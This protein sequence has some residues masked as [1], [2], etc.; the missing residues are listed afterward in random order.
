MAPALGPD[1]VLAEDVEKD[2]YGFIMPALSDGG[3]Q[4]SAGVA[5]GPADVA[6]SAQSATAAALK[7]IQAVRA[8]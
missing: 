7:A 4:V 6:L 5:A 1:F 8:G 2:E 3:G